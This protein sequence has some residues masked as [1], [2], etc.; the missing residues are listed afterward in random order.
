[1]FFGDGRWKR[2]WRR[3]G[4]GCVWSLDGVCLCELRRD[5]MVWVIGG[6][7]RWTEM[8]DLGGVAWV[9]NAEDVL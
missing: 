2:L 3:M 4:F 5:E 8:R 1:M 6:P 7:T 9:W